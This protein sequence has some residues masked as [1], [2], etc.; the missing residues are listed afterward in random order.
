MQKLL[1]VAQLSHPWIIWTEPRTGGTA[2]SAAL[3][4]VS[5]HPAVE[6]EPFQYGE[7]PKQFAH[8]YEAWCETGDTLA[9][10]RLLGRHVLIKHIPEAFDDEFN[11]EL[12]RAAE[13]HGYRHVRLVRLDIFARLVSRSVAEQLDAWE[14]SRARPA[15]ANITHLE[16]LDVPH[17]LSDFRLGNARWAALQRGITSCLTICT[18]DVV[19]RYHDRRHKCLRLLLRFLGLAPGLISDVDAILQNSGQN[20]ESVW[21][22]IPNL[23]ELRTAMALEGAI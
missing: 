11:S 18:E 20:T 22:L 3:K 14:V 12:V 10:S 2:L 16:P 5:E 19:S 6:D 8:I 7:H 23:R 15:L 17:L 21:H 9:L 4:A 13:R 1:D